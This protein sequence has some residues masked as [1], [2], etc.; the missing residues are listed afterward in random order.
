MKISQ[1]KI[2]VFLAL[3]GILIVPAT[4]SAVSNQNLIAN[5]SFENANDVGDMPASW[6]IGGWGV[7]VSFFEYLSSLA[8]E[9][10][11]SVRVTLA[12]QLDGDNNPIVL[13]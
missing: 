4:I 10:N 1:T 3:V 6:T 8:H 5:Y 7:N 2:V 11:K 13:T 9:G 12:Q